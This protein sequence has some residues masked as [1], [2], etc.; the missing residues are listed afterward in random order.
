VRASSGSKTTNI[1]QE[2]WQGSVG[3]QLL[4][5]RRNSWISGATAAGKVADDARLD[6]VDFAY[7]LE[8]FVLETTSGTAPVVQRG[9]EVRRVRINMRSGAYDL[10]NSTVG[11]Q[12]D[13]SPF[14]GAANASRFAD[15]AASAIKSFHSAEAG[16][17]SFQPGKGGF[18]ATAVFTPSSNTLRVKPGD[19]GGLGMYAKAGD[20]GRATGA[21][22]TL[23][24]PANASFSPRTARTPSPQ[25][26]YRVVGSPSGNQVQVTATFTST[27]GVGKDT[28]T[29][30]LEALPVRFEGTFSGEGLD[31]GGTDSESVD[32]V[33]T[34]SFTG[35][36]KGDAMAH[37]SLGKGPQTVGYLELEMTGEGYRYAIGAQFFDTFQSRQINATCY[38][39]PKTI[40]WTPEAFVQTG[41][42]VYVPDV[43]ELKG[44]S[45]AETYKSSWDL[46]GSY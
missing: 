10:A 42:D 38:G 17:T 22:W 40:P 3:S 11:I 1:A 15:A 18:C 37:V 7:S 14:A 43:R 25:V 19:S 32:F 9:T 36:C 45:D 12:G 26:T 30:P 29:Q 46:T 4:V 2:I 21:R 34:L 35:S 44:T 31:P 39:E 5:R 33:D 6:H 20:G 41:G 23:I 24:S 28:W 8:Q 27:A 16:W 13:A